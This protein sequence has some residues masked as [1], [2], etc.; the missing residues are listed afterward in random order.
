MEA[1]LFVEVYLEE[2]PEVVTGLWTG[3]TEDRIQVGADFS[4]LQKYVH[5]L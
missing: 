2:G 5:C 1:F 4:H 3:R